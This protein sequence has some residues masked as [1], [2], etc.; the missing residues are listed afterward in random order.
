MDSNSNKCDNWNVP[1]DIVSYLDTFALYYVTEKPT[2]KLKWLHDWVQADVAFY[3][4]TEGKSTTTSKNSSSSLNSQTCKRPYS[5]KCNAQFAIICNA[6]NQKLEYTK[7]ELQKTT[8][9]DGCSLDLFVQTLISVGIIIEDENF[10]TKLRLNVD[11][12]SPR[13]KIDLVRKYSELRHK[14]NQSQSSSSKYKEPSSISDYLE[15]LTQGETNTRDAEL[16]GMADTQELNPEEE[17]QKLK[18]LEEDRA[19]YLQAT[20]VRIMKK[21]KKLKHNLLVS[22]V[23]EV[24]KHRFVPNVS[25]IKKG[26]ESLIDKQFLE[27]LVDDEYE[28]MT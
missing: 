15:P 17:S 14:K 12:D 5:L 2:T 26:I 18:A 13:I 6:F 28:Y 11:F 24:S 16:D 21:S 20:I 27:R 9:I 19:T 7:C 8:G 25:S 4:Y 10:S 1:K 22:E 3:V 23:I